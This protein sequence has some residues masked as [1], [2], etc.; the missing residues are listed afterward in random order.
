MRNGGPW[1][2]GPAQWRLS[3]SHMH[4]YG[5]LPAGIRA[6]RDRTRPLA[7]LVQ[8]EHIVLRRRARDRTPSSELG[9]IMSLAIALSLA[10]LSLDRDR[11]RTLMISPRAGTEPRDRVR[12]PQAAGPTTL[13]VTRICTRARRRT[14]SLVLDL[15]DAYVPVHVHGTAQLQLQLAHT[16]TPALPGTRRPPHTAERP[17]AAQAPPPPAP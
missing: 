2:Q 9:L 5:Q 7:T 12:P 11:I 13:H 3:L 16:A 14:L 10:P 15:V 8:S 17:A 6:D 1:I 4:A